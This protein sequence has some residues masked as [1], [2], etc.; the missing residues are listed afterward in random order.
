M[1]EPTTAAVE[2]LGPWNRCVVI[3]PSGQDAPRTW[4]CWFP[5]PCPHHGSPDGT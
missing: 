4:R 3:V 5:L 2:S 1:P